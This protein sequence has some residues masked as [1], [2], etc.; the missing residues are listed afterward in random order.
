MEYSLKMIKIHVLHC[1]EVCVDEAIPFGN[2][3]KNPLAFTGIFRSQKNRIW[4]PVSAYLIEHPKGLILFDTGW[5][6]NVRK[7]PIGHLTRKQ[8]LV[9]QP[10]LSE[11]ESIA[12]QLNLLG[13]KSSDLDYVIMSHMD[14]DHV[15]GLKL[16]SDAKNI[17]TSD[18]ELEDALKYKIRY[19][20][21]MWEGVVV[22]TFKLEQTGDGPVGLSYDLF[23][24]GS[25]NLI[26]IPGHSHG[27]CA[28]KITNN[29]GK[30]VLLLSDG[31]Y[32]EKSWKEMI[33]PGITLDKK[34]AMEYLQW[35]HDMSSSSDCVESLA[36][37]DTGKKPH[38][39]EL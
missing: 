38:V 20:S 37:H 1:G 33:L 30:Y 26:N 24:D 17:L 27:L 34:Q 22:N 14:S 3:S 23:G 29:D 8:F 28:M 6:T 31:C 15:S 10:R 13:F 21:S 35:I 18:K 4:L 12:E 19:V 39:I 25:I 2:V 9:N 5:H 32:A 36:C 16:V 7:D 11:G